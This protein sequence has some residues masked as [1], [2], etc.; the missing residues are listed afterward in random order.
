[1]AVCGNALLCK[2]LPKDGHELTA[3]SLET[4]EAL[5][6]HDL[7]AEVAA[8]HPIDHKAHDRWDGPPMA[9]IGLSTY[10]TMASSVDGRY[11]ATYSAALFGC[12]LQNGRVLWKA[13]ALDDT[14]RLLPKYG[15]VPVLNMHRGRFAVVEEQLGRVVVDRSH[16]ELKSMFHVRGRVVMNRLAIFVTDSGHLAGLDIDNGELAWYE[17]H[18]GIS[19]RG[20]GLDGDRLFV[21]ASDGHLWIYA[22]E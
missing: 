15:L 2:G 22:N 8:L 11:L 18:S 17:H 21:M 20:V 7:L 19:F 1:M 13:D 3:V 6:A 9:E 10:V 4:G 16:S 14:H 5:W 12:S